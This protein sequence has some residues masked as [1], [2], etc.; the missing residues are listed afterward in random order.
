MAH[1]PTILAQVLTWV[2]RWPIEALDQV[3]GTGRPRRGLSRWSQFG[4]LVFAQLAGRHRWRDVA[5]AL[6]FQAHAHALALLGLRLPK[7]ATL[8][9][10][11]ARRPVVL[12]QA[13]LETL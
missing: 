10:A 6:A 13:L 9:E 5:W 12:Y 3:Y 11:H 1:N 4:A 7:H 2:L 8:A